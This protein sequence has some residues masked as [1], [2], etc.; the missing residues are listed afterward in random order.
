MFCPKYPLPRPARA[1][2]C[3][4]EPRAG[5]SRT[6]HRSPQA[7]VPSLRSHS[8]GIPATDAPGVQLIVNRPERFPRAASRG[9]IPRGPEPADCSSGPCN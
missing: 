9:R 1:A 6:L 8:H 5:D 4:A 3:S 2:P 7:T